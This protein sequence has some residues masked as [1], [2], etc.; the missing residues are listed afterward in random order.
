N[1]SYG[2]LINHYNVL[3]TLED[4]YDLS[5]A[6]NSGSVQPITD[7]WASVATATPTSPPTNTP[8]PTETDTPIPTATN[9]PTFTPLSTATDTPTPQAILVGHVTWQGRPSQ[10]NPL[11]QVPITLTLKQGTTEVN[12]PAQATDAFGFFTVSV[13]SMPGGLYNWRVKDPK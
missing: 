9:T 5:Y 10:P 1:G 12:Y 2:E 8:I 13:A 4:M 6:G 11:Q 7:V 3:R